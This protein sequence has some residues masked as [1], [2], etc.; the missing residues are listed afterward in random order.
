MPE[1]G[2]LQNV[3]LVI[4]E[5]AHFRVIVH[6]EFKLLRFVVCLVFEKDKEVHPE[7]TL[8]YSF[9]LLRLHGILFLHR[10]KV[11]WG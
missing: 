2:L 8:L 7:G 4:D 9:F 11:S 6:P 10:K 5:L 1:V 3:Y